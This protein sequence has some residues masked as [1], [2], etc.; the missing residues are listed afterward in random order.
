MKLQ[1]GINLGG[2]L[3]QCKYERN[4]YETFITEKDIQTIAT[5]GFDHVRLPIDYE[6]LETEDGTPIDTNIDLIDQALQWC[7]Q[8]QLDVIIDLHKAPGYDFNNTLNE[9]DSESPTASNTLFDNEILQHRFIALWTRLA[10]RYGHLKHVAFELL[11][12]VVS[13]DFIKPWNI[14]IKQAVE[15]IRKYAPETT[16]IYG[17]VEWNS[18]KK[19]STLEPPIDSNIVFTFHYYEPI[20]FTHQK[21]YWI[22]AID[23][24]EEIPYN[25]DILWYKMKAVKMGPHGKNVIASKVNSMGIPYHEE[26]LKEALEYS[27]KLGVK[28]YC[29]EFGVIDQAPTEDSL[30][31]YQDI[32]GLFNKYEI[33]YSVWSYKEMDFGILGE[34][35]DKVRELLIK[36]N[37]KH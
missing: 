16:I 12:E 1:R 23:S 35:Y 28:L 18:V 27:K 33:G 13:P 9:S 21:A 20:L 32:L 34:H 15:A 3:S 8:A 30:K 17:G 36:L 7:K 29:G 24:N 26:L 31:W 10:K 6:V 25:D 14:L 37:Q 22:D 4:H 2:Y 5:W 11:N 19:I